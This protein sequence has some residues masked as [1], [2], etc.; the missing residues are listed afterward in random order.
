MKAIVF[1]LLAG[2]CWGVGEVLT[3][4]VLH[5]RQI[6]PLTA[7]A[8]RTTVALPVLW[9]AYAVAV[10]GAELEPRAWFRSE[11]STLIKLFIGSGLIA[12]AG[13]MIFFYAALNLDE[14]SRIKPI[15]FTVAPAVG[16]VLGWLVLREP[17]T[18]Q[19]AVGVLMVVLGVVLLSVRTQP[20]T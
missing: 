8:V 2:L 5:T 10:H 1:A 19:K 20:A 18:L 12:G 17:M 16:V 4:S 11:S 9:L 15:A 7:I 13:G 6:G 3:K 14:V